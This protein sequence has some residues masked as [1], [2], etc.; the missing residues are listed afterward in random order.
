MKLISLL[1]WTFYLFT[2]VTLDTDIKCHSL[3]K[4]SEA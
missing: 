2:L 3:V 1:L 4:E